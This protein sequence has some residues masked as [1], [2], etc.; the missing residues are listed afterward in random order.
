MF[1]EHRKMDLYRMMKDLGKVSVDIVDE[2][3]NCTEKI[4]TNYDEAI[5]EIESLSMFNEVYF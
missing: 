1:S 4:F 5:Q 3:G 2:D